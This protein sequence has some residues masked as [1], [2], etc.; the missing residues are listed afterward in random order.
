MATLS[1]LCLGAAL[2]AVL[3][4]CCACGQA[5]GGT[6]E[7]DSAAALVAAAR[8][9][10][11]GTTIL[12]APGEY[13]GGISLANLE[14]REGAPIVIAARDDA[15]PPV[16]VG[17]NGGIHLVRP[18]HVELR[19]LTLQGAA[20]NGLNIDDGGDARQPA[21]HLVL[22]GLRI[23]DIGPRGNRDGIK[24]SGVDQFQVVDC[25]IERWGDGGSAID[26]VGCHDGEVLNCQFRHRADIPANGVQTKGGSSN[27][28]IRGCRFEDAGDRGVNIGGST[29]RPFFRPPGANYEARQIT[30]ED[31]TFRGSGAPVAFVGV[32]GAVVR[33][34]TIYRPTRYVLRILQETQAAEFIP[35]RNG[36]FSNNLIVF[37]SGDLRSV[38]NVGGGTAP[39]TFTFANNHWYCEDAPARSDR[40]GLPTAETGGRY[41]VDP[42][43]I[44]AAQGDLR[45]QPDSPVRD[46]GVRVATP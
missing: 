18:R 17:G 23:R 13:R 19:N 32:D 28:A 2:F 14:G 34:N 30:V 39:E 31:C 3:T 25:I 5:A 44:D 4:P 8:Q 43:L 36:T 37:R 46:A 12:L 15:Q 40:L 6:V 27:I 42:R 41:G 16:I 10:R 35:C 22:R 26:M 29:G 20:G 7:V 38:V 21:G 45:L 9:A 11:P 33:H 24:L 1:R